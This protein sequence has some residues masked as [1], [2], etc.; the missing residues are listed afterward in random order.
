MNGRDVAHPLCPA[1]GRPEMYGLGIRCAF[2]VQWFGAV[3]VEYYDEDDLP[4]VRHLG[5]FLSAA[6]TTGLIIQIARDDL[7]TIDIYLVLLLAIGTFFFLIPIYVWRVLTR[8]NPNL[9][10]FV[11]SK[12]RHGPVY[13]YLTFLLLVADASV[14]TW[15]YTSHLPQLDRDCRQYAFVFGRVN[16]EEKVYIAFTAI[17]YICILIACG[18]LLIFTPCCELR[19]IIDERYWSRVRRVHIA[20]LHTARTL[21]GLAVFGVLVAA[22]ELTISWNNINHVD[23]VDTLSQLIPLFLSALF[24][25]RVWVLHNVNRQQA[26]SSETTVSESSPNG[27]ENAQVHGTVPQWPPQAYRRSLA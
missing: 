14:G 25:L 24:V 17:F 8:C 6:A 12:E 16:I 2:Y 27:P 1:Q 19:S 11:L 15:F 22:I 20:L 21:V 7:E 23:D 13:K 9:D 5:A 3:I 4:D 10:P 26:S 18:C